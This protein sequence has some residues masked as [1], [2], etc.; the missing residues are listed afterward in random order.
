MDMT[1]QR[2]ENT[3]AYL[4]EVFGRQDEDLADLRNRAI[5]RGLPDIGAQLLDLD[6][7]GNCEGQFITGDRGTGDR[8]VWIGSG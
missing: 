4:Q 6:E 1:P 8:Q 7:P 5:A 3:C 2:W